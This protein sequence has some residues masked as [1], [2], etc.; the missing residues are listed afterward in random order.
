MR[1]ESFVQSCRIAAPP[2]VVY[3]WHAA[4]GALERLTPPWERVNVEERAGGIEDGPRVVLR[5]GIG[6]LRIRW[7]ALHRDYVEGKQFRDEQIN[8]P[9]AHWIHT[10]GFQPDGPNACLLEDRVEYALPFGRG[11]CSVTGSPGESS[12]GYLPTGTPLCKTI[13]WLTGVLGERRPC[14][15]L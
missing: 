10:H 13:S 3:R 6:P 8:G 5:V 11:A 7:T 15:S 14:I 12:R 9:F 1:T 2:D 4:P